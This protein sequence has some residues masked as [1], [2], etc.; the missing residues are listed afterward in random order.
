MV[1]D[2]T[3]AAVVL[4][5]VYWLFEVA[6]P[7]AWSPDSRMLLWGYNFNKVRMFETNVVSRRR[8]RVSHDDRL[9]YFAR[10]S[11]NEMTFLTYTGKYQP[12]Y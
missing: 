1:V 6:C 8:V 10:W 7:L 5:G 12:N 9:W 11:R 2:L 4:S 3:N